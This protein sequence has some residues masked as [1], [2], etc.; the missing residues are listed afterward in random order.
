MK[1][2]WQEQQIKWR[3]FASWIV[4]IC[5]CKSASHY[6][7]LYIV[8]HDRHSIYPCQCQCT[9]WLV[10][11]L[12]TR[13][14]LKSIT[15]YHIPIWE[16]HVVITSSP[17]SF[18]SILWCCHTRNHPRGDLPRFGYRPAMKA[19]IYQN[20]FIY[21]LLAWTMCLEICKFLKKLLHFWLFSF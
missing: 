1:I 20:P 14:V 2:C 11:S 5:F 18:S 8:I 16:E 13:V 3:S 9:L 19:E 6:W 10:Q 17:V 12:L 4:N 21:W 15:K 7:D